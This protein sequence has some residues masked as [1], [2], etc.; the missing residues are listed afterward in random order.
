MGNALR[1]YR[2]QIWT[3]NLLTA[4]FWMWRYLKPY[5]THMRCTGLKLDGTPERIFVTYRTHILFRDVH[6]ATGKH[7]PS[8]QTWF[9]I[10]RR[11]NRILL[12]FVWTWDLHRLFKNFQNL[13]GVSYVCLSKTTLFEHLLERVLLWLQ[14]EQLKF[15]LVLVELQ[16]G[17]SFLN[18]R[19][20]NPGRP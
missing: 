10:K 17:Y 5:G 4:V 9:L 1:Y 2:Y 7:I 19:I 16:F 6:F 8:W 18:D 20:K 13:F 12:V 14:T 3:P 11:I 15:V